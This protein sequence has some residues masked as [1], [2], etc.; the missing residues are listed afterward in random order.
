MK[1]YVFVTS[2]LFLTTLEA[3]PF[4]RPLVPPTPQCV[5]A[6]K[7]LV[8]YNTDK[9]L[10][11]CAEGVDVKCV[12]T[13]NPL[14]GYD[15]DKALRSCAEGAEASCVEK[16]KPVVGYDTQKALEACAT[17]RQRWSRF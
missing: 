4:R 14:V 2:L 7:P 10:N 8:G 11:A 17:R 1:L 13:M 3:R 15:T 6:A 16:M 12:E 9:A 5:E